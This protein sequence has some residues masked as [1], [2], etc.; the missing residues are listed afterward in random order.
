MGSVVG[1]AANG[2]GTFL[3]NVGTWPFKTVFGRSCKD[4]CSGAWDFLCFLEN[5]CLPSLVRMLVALIVLFCAVYLAFKLH[6]V[7]CVTKI[8]CK[9]A[10]RTCSG[11]CHAL[12]GACCY[13]YR[14]VR[15]TKRVR[16]GRWGGRHWPDVEE[17]ELS[18]SYSDTDF[19]DDD[20]DW[21]T[22]AGSTTTS[23]ARWR[24]SSSLSS[25][26]WS[27]VRERTKDRLRQ[28]LR[29]RRTYSKEGHVARSHAGIEKKRHRH[30]SRAKVSISPT[31]V[32]VGARHGRDHAETHREDEW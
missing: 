9:A 6:I 25:S 4:I 17:G 32:R 3:W 30:F 31:R 7:R 10:W 16:R 18:S 15:D 22:A 1:T 14:K 24:S 20:S 8:T 19:S 27:S 13:L 28:S 12:C 11:C 23:R 2:A 26:S 5:I 29:V 21:D